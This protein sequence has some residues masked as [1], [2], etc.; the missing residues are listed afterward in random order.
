MAVSIKDVAK[1]AN[2]CPSTVSRVI[3][4]TVK[5]KPETRARVLEAIRKLNY[6]PNSTARALKLRRTDT[7]GVILPT[8]T[9]AFFSDI[10]RG[11]D[12]I[13]VENGFHLIVSSSR[14]H[15]REAEMLLQFVMADRVDGVIL[16]APMLSD[17]TIRN[18]RLSEFPIV[19]LNKEVGDL[20]LDSFVV[21]N[22]HGAFQAI[23]HLIEHRYRRIG[24][25][26][27]HPENLDSQQRLRAYKDALRQA[28][29]KI[30]NDLIVEGDFQIKGGYSA[31]LKLL[32]LDNPPDAVF[33]A[34][35][36]MAQGA[37]EAIRSKGLTIPDSIAIVGFDDIEIASYMQP[38][39]TTVRFP[40]YHLGSLAAQSLIRTIREGRIRKERIVL[41]TELVVRSSCGC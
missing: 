17:E 12:D 5:V 39:L 35:D 23:M 14:A 8:I 33:V 6:V 29:L 19:V 37:Y 41:K 4:G 18:V 26:C 20:D 3:N 32:E 13:V 34:N 15:R 40:A 30:E 7:I 27:G 25:I 10:I 21:D 38:P 28:G 36:S 31:M 2:V 9:G 1:E 24:M 16:M 11:I 22:Y